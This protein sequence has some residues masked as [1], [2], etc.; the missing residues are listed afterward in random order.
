MNNKVTVGIIGD[1][2]EDHPARKV[3]DAAL[4]HAAKYLSIDVD[5]SWILT[6]SLTTSAGLQ[7]LERFGGI[8]GAPGGA[9]DSCDGAVAGIQYARENK[10]PF[11]GT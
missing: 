3:T 1:A 6:Q 9:Y 8:V 10:H 4:N 2:P 11:L 5:F 7:G